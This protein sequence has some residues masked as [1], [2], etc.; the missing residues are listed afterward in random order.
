MNKKNILI[1]VGL[2][3]LVVGFVL[4]MWYLAQPKP[5]SPE[6]EKLSLCLKEKGAKMYGAYWC[7]HCQK[8]KAEF[9]E[10]FK[11][12]LYVEC[13]EKQDECTAA[14]IEGYPTWVFS[15]GSKLSGE[16]D[17]KVLADKA[18]CPFPFKN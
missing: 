4:L 17:L 9:G 7:S 13:T 15:D 14:G 18:G 11:N 12:I 3:V 16:Q 6:V 5:M 1:A 8:Q 2:V 10:A